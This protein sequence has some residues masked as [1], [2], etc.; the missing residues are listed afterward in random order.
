MKIKLAHI[1]LS[2][3]FLL[4]TACVEKDDN[5]NHLETVNSI[6]INVRNFADSEIITRT[7]AEVNEKGVSFNWSENDTIG[8]FPTRGYQVA[9]PMSLG[10]G[11]QNAE[12]DG[13]DWGLKASTQ[14]SAYYPFEYYNRSNKNVAISYVGQKQIGNNTTDHIGRYDYMAAAVTTP[15][16]GSVSFD[17]EHLGSLIQWKIKMPEPGN[18]TKLS[19]RCDNPVFTQ[20]GK[21]DL[22]AQ[23]MHIE[24][25]DK[26]KRAVVELENISTTTADEEIIVYMMMPPTDLAGQNLSVIIANDQGEV[27]ESKIT[28]KNFEAGKA[29]SI[30]VEEFESYEEE[31]IEIIGSSTMT[32]FG[33]R[34]TL[35]LNFRTN[36]PITCEISEEAK[37]WITPIE[38]RVVTEQNL[39]FDI[40]ENQGYANRYGTIT[41]TTLKGDATATYHIT[42]E[43]PYSYVITEEGGAFPIGILTCSSPATSK[44][45]GLYALLDD[46]MDTYFEAESNQLKIIWKGKEEHQFFGFKVGQRMNT[47][48]RE[49]ENMTPQFSYNGID[50]EGSLGIGHA[51]SGAGFQYD[52]RSI[53]KYTLSYKCKH[54]RFYVNKNKDAHTIRIRELRLITDPNTEFNTDLDKYKKKSHE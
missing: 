28:S 40:V 49:W 1:F 51:L 26:N 19:L 18:F 6:R 47:P 30:T 31:F 37:Q 27:K 5:F 44:E 29:Y 4:W 11:T 53:V 21:L 50:W 3:V 14:Y 12:F 7:T 54:Y 36:T 2:A 13:G 52:F 48:E 24:A 34:E 17:F 32:L 10:S 8:I 41:L 25:I 22:T 42:Q 16:E 43:S 39:M 20:T 23:P 46:D 38:S 9:F 45:H 15:E 35:T 33:N